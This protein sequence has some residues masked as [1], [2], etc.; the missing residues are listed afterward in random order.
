MLKRFLSS[1]YLKL[2]LIFLLKRL[3]VFPL[4]LFGFVQPTCTIYALLLCSTSSIVQGLFFQA[5]T[6]YLNQVVVCYHCII[7]R[8]TQAQ[9]QYRQLRIL[10]GLAYTL[11]LVS[12]VSPRRSS[13]ISII[14]QCQLAIGA[15]LLL[16]ISTQFRKKKQN[17]ETLNIKQ[18]YLLICFLGKATSIKQCTESRRQ[19]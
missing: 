12:P 6:C 7:S 14:A 9:T 5:I 15:V 16:W 3:S 11:G 13:S 10:V 19:K 18:V 17:Y 4:L 2:L 1:I 8:C